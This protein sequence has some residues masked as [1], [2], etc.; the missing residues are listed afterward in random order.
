[1]FFALQFDPGSEMLAPSYTAWATTAP[2]HLF[3]Y[4]PSFVDIDPRSMTFDLD[5]ARKRL[6]SRT[7]AILVMH[8]FGNPCD[9]DQI[10]EFAREK[11]LLVLE[12][13]AQAQ[14][15]SL[16][17]KPVGTW[18]AMGVFSFQSSKV[19]PS[20]GRRDLPDAR[21]LRTGYNVRQLRA[22]EYVSCP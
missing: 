15:A 7:K 8:S 21:A 1:M 17:T 14:G 20:R 2:M 3:Q 4:V 16:Q 13:A 6:N 12:D 22:P 9:M 10:C 18:G 19:L 5:Y 11:G